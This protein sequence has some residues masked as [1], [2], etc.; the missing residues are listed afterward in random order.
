MRQ[1]LNKILKVNCPTC[2][3]KF[4]Y[5]LS[6]FRPFC[7]ERCKLIDLGQWLDGSY[8][9]ESKENLSDEDLEKVIKEQSKNEEDQ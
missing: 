8:T 7:C 1:K 5:N 3:K 4:E 9:V 6:E 2:E